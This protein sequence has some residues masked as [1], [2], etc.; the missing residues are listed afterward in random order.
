MGRRID[1]LNVDRIER[2]VIT[3][4][5]GR[6]NLD[7]ALPDHIKPENIEIPTPSEDSATALRTVRQLQQLERQNLMLALEKSQ[8][9]VAGKEGAAQLVG[10]P[11]STFQLRMKAL[12]IKRP[13]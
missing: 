10:M 5:K 1:P 11:P 7:H 13:R 4:R 12:Q 9:R 2:G 3:A 8:W 6:L